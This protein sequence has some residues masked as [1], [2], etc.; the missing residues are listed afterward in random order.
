M[1]DRTARR[2][3]FAM[4]NPPR[5]SR[6]SLPRHAQTSAGTGSAVRLICPSTW[7]SSMHGEWLRDGG[8]S[9]LHYAAIRKAWKIQQSVQKLENIVCMQSRGGRSGGWLNLCL[10]TG[11]WVESKLHLPLPLRADFW[12]CNHELNRLKCLIGQQRNLGR[13]SVGINEWNTEA[14]G[15]TAAQTRDI[16]LGLNMPCDSWL[17]DRNLHVGHLN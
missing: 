16:S 2:Y 9:P 8:E 13:L 1:A 17:S 7:K 5:R 11:R 4:M 10:Y 14:N 3:R 12:S 6:P 15:N